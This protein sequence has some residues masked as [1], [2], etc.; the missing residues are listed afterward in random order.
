MPMEM[1]LEDG[2]RGSGPQARLQGKADPDAPTDRGAH[3]RQQG[4]AE[5][6]VKHNHPNK[7]ENEND[8]TSIVCMPWEGERE[9]GSGRQERWEGERKGGE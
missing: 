1:A 6:L 4:R 7:R 2:C 3:R 5:Q 8:D 9:G